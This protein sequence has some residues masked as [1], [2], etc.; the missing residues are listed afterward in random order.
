MSAVEVGGCAPPVYANDPTLP[1]EVAYSLWWACGDIWH[2]AYDLA[3]KLRA[4]GLYDVASKIEQAAGCA[5]EASCLMQRFPRMP[6]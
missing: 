6:A 4:E 3:K 1:P 2:A 5:N